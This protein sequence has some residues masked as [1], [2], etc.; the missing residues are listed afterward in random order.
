MTNSLSSDTLKYLLDEALEDES[1]KVLE[2]KNPCKIEW[3]GKEY[4]IYVKNICDAFQ[5]NNSSVTRAQ[6]PRKP[7]FDE[8][9]RSQIPFI[10]LGYASGY[11]VYATWNPGMVKQRLNTRQYIS[12]YSRKEIQQQACDEGKF[13]KADLSNKG[14]VLVF[15]RAA[16]CEY[17]NKYASFFP[18]NP[19]YVAVGS[20]ARKEA[21]EIFRT[22]VAPESFSYYKAHYAALL[23]IENTEADLGLLKSLIDVI[24]EKDYRKY[25]LVYDNFADYIQGVNN[26]VDGVFKNSGDDDKLKMKL[27]LNGYVIVIYRKFLEENAEKKKE[28]PEVENGKVIRIK[29]ISL[30]KQIKPFLVQ[31][32]P[33]PLPAVDLVMK[34]F[35]AKYDNLSSMEFADWMKLVKQIDWNSVPE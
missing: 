18:E 11:D 21:N 22:F 28:E 23:P 29:D 1:Y 6:L 24:K 10:F 19:I 16:L 4:Y 5:G 3:H 7:F 17:L 20:K 9:K 25:F 2:G 12:L 31:Q 27:T 35:T 32:C 15:P 14:E 33:Q 13:V 26:F 8:V 34:H 30:L